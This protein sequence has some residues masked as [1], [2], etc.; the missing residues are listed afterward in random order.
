[1]EEYKFGDWVSGDK[2]SQNIT[3]TVHYKTTTTSSTTSKTVQT[4]TTTT[5]TT[6]KTVQTTTTTS[7]TNGVSAN[8]IDDEEK[9]EDSS[10]EFETLNEDFIDEVLISDNSSDQSV[11]YDD[12]IKALPIEDRE[13]TKVEF[14][15]FEFKYNFNLF[16]ESINWGYC[17]SPCRHISSSLSC[18]CWSCFLEE[19]KKI[20]GSGCSA[21]SRSNKFN[22]C[23]YNILFS[24]QR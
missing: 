2:H 9:S 3:V 19:E 6:S 4:T 12:E 5:F 13:V 18:H 10:V 23:Y 16:T 20:N 24:V 8:I 15:Y 17:W 1:M 14:R 11:I 21:Q 22:K 7:V